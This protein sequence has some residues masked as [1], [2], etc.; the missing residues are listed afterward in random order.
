MHKV[1]IPLLEGK[2]SAGF[3]SSAENFIDKSLDINDLII[4]HP[5]ATFFIRVKGDSMI[6]AGIHSDDILVVDRALSPSNNRIIIARIN[7]ELTVKRIKIENNKVY[8]VPAND[9]YTPIEISPDMYFEVWG[10]VSFIIH[11]AV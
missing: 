3:P 5:A 2:V 7:D 10:V 11:R 8:L 1:C 4:K 9:N 6:D